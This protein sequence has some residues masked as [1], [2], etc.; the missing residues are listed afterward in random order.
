MF[1]SASNMVGL[2]ETWFAICCL[3]YP[4]TQKQS[5]TVTV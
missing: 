4:V 3:F 2:Q 5:C 1:Y